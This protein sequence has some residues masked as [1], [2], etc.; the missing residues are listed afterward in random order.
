MRRLDVSFAKQ[1]NRPSTQRSGVIVILKIV[2]RY[3][4]SSEALMVSGSVSF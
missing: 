2:F 3:P 1:N 4:D